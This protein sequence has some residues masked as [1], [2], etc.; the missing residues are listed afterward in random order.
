VDI[1]TGLVVVFAGWMLGLAVL[2]WAGWDDRYYKARRR[3]RRSYERMPPHLAALLVAEIAALPRDKARAV[4]QHPDM[5]PRCACGE[6]WCDG[7]VITDHGF[8]HTEDRCQP[9]REAL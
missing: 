1:V 9:S 3:R 4:L 2:A 6:Y 5:R 7:M 8:E